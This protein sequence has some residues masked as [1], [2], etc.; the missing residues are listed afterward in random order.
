[1]NIEQL[2]AAREWLKEILELDPVLGGLATT[3]DD[4]PHIK[5]IFD[6]LDRAINAPDLESLKAKPLS[7]DDS[8]H[9]RIYIHGYNDAI[10]QLSAKGLITN[11]QKAVMRNP[12]TEDLESLKQNYSAEPTSSENFYRD[13]W[14]EC[15]DYLAPRIVREGFVVVPEEPTEEMSLTFRREWQDM[16]IRGKLRSEMFKAAYKALLSA[17]PTPSSTEKVD[18]ESGENDNL[19]MAIV[20]NGIPVKNVYEAY[21]AGCDVGKSTRTEKVDVESL[22]IGQPKSGSSDK[23]WGYYDGYNQAVRYLANTGRLR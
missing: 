1:M 12:I 6:L 2:K 7:D 13:G 4:E 5:I 17:A 20:G 16:D 19:V 21:Q 18:V 3:E 23:E 10:D 9:T 11:K 14:N 15:I 22:L 8:A